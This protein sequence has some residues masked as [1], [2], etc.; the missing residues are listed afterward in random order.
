MKAVV[1]LFLVLFFLLPARLT[2]LDAPVTTIPSSQAC[3][4]TL[5]SLPVTVTAFSDIGSL[6]LKLQYD[7]A[8]LAFHAWNNTAGFPGLSLN[9]SLSGVLVI[10]GFTTQPG[11][12]TLADSAVFFTVTFLF[13][14]GTSPLTWLN[15]G[16]S[17]EYTGPAPDFPVLNDLPSNIFYINGAVAPSLVADFT[18]STRLP[19]VAETVIFTDLSTGLPTSWNW[20]F[21]P[22]SY[23]FVNGTAANFKN[24][25]VQFTTNGPYTVSLS[26]RTHTCLVSDSRSNWIHV[27]NPGVWTGLISSNW[28]EDANWHNWIVPDASTD[29]VIPPDAENWPEYPGDFTIGIQCLNLTIQ[30]TTGQMTVTG[31][32]IIP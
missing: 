16:S 22:A 17:C 24:P 15:I 31:D 9:N 19:G 27:G 18:A 3:P 14:G 26:V 23:Q 6:S 4:G 2:A 7:T 21:S 30:G 1:T 13:K 32:F 10:G 20:S 28:N 11:G 5:I 25:Q 29:V 12:I 8:A